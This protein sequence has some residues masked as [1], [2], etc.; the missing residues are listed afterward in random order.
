M[1]LALRP[2]GR[3]RSRSIARMQS[4]RLLAGLSSHELEL[5]TQVIFRGAQSLVHRHASLA[6]TAIHVVARL[7]HQKTTL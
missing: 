7:L 1:K 2:K 3:C 5:E 4:P 6:K